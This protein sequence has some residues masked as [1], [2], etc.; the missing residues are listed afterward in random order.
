MRRVHWLRVT[1]AAPSPM[2]L[3]DWLSPP[4]PMR[5]T[6]QS[7][8][9]QTAPIPI[10]PTPMVLSAPIPSRLPRRMALAARQSRRRRRW[11]LATLCTI[12]PRAAASS[13]VRAPRALSRS[14]TAQVL[15][16]IRPLLPLM[17]QSTSAPA[18]P[19]PTRRIRGSRAPI[20]SPSPPP[21]PMAWSPPPRRRRW[22]FPRSRPRP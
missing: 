20:P 8:W 9:G 13:P 1:R 17:V 2:T 15:P 10:L 7:P 3:P 12:P 4:P 16:P 21:T 6:V 14:P 11:L 19:I 22:L 5:H 18:A